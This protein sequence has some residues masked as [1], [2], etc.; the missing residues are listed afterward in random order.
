L[1]LCTDNAAMIAAAGYY[2]F[3]LGQTSPLDMDVQP[4]WPLS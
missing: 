3:A 2:R 1:W 4:T